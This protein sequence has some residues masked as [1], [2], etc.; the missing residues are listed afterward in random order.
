LQARADAPTRGFEPLERLAA[1][2]RMAPE[3][4]RRILADLAVQLAE[5][6]RAGCV[7]GDISPS[8][9]GLDAAGHA[10]LLTPPVMPA[11]NAE[12]AL[13]R[14]G[15]AAFEQYTDDPDTPC[16]PWTDIYAMSATACALL[17][18]LAPPPA[19]ARCIRDDYIPLARRCEQDEREFHRALDSGLAMDIR[20]RP[21]TVEDFARA[22]GIDAAVPAG[23]AHRAAPSATRP[24][25]PPSA[26]PAAPSDAAPVAPSDAAPSDAAPVAPSDAAAAAP[27]ASGTPATPASPGALA[28]VRQRVPLLIILAVIFVAG[29]ALYAWLRPHAERPDRVASAVTESPQ[30]PASNVKSPPPGQLQA[31]PPQASPPQANPPQPA[32]SRA[33]SPQAGSSQATAPAATTNAASTAAGET[34]LADAATT[35]TTPGDTAAA[36]TAT[37]DTATADSTPADT[38]AADTATADIARTGHTAAAAGTRAQVDNISAPAAPSAAGSDTATP[39]RSASV[40]A[41]AAPAGKKP[42]P[43]PASQ[44]QPKPAAQPTVPVAVS[45]RPWGEVLVN[46]KSRGVSPPLKSLSLA[47][48]KYAITLRNNAGPDYRQTLV[49]V[50]GKPASISH[51]FR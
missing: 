16:G 42:A 51:T 33:D 18:G 6:H 50:P 7:H 13:R 49:V 21:R 32:S 4:V 12:H 43:A 14:E 38:T 9:V 28:A 47:P 34:T 30:T 39:N 40:A 10:R 26:R 31:T 15:Y 24:V 44:Q 46:G 2:G 17:T 5:L 36:D 19:L 37:A 35:A 25:A 22:L 23:G 20:A 8:T 41:T 45:I 48:G 11:P 1:A 3:R 27:V 29:A